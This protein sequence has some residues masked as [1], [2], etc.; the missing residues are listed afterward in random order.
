MFGLLI[1]LTGCLVLADKADD[2]LV[3]LY[4]ERDADRVAWVVTG[5]EGQMFAQM[6]GLAATFHLVVGRIH[7]ARYLTH[8]RDVPEA[9]CRAA[10]R[11]EVGTWFK[12][13]LAVA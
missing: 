9:A 4:E 2:D 13:E 1:G 8:M 5:A 11:V 6:D 3:V 7:A 12:A 10:R